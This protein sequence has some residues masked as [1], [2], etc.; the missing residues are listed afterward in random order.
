MS[1]QDPKKQQ[2]GQDAPG[3]EEEEA[4]PKGSG[5]ASLTELYE[6]MSR[7]TRESLE[8]AGTI[9]EEALERALREGREWGERMRGYYSEDVSRVSEFLRRDWY[10]SVRQVR[11]QTQRGLDSMQAGVLG[12]LARLARAA[13]GSLEGFADRLSERLT[14]KTGEIAG[15]GDLECSGCGQVIRFEKARR[16]PPC[17]KCH[18]TTFRRHV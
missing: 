12:S 10:E 18:T 9:S 14:Y 4:D 8:R 11:S 3:P 2:P 7:V 16:I 5:G 17:P 15:A 13:G 1:E 6:R